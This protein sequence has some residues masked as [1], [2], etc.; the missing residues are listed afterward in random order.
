M[1]AKT[2]MTRD[3]VCLNPEDSIASA[4]QLMTKWGIRHIPIIE[5]TTI[6]GILSDRDIL[7]RSHLGE[8]GLSVPDIPVADAMTENP[9][10]CSPET[11]VATM[12]DLMLEHKIDSLPIVNHQ[13]MLVG[14]VTS[15][16]LLE[17]LRVQDQEYYCS[18][19][20]LTFTLRQGAARLSG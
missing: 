9:I 15:S 6:I 12:V 5:D 1:K 3:I 16:D 17:V 18:T 14:L 4:Y 11:P 2:A 13:G 20:P 7:V 10:T 8:F 19:I